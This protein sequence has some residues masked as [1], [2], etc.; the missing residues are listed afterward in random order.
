M[1]TVAIPMGSQ[2]DI[3]TLVTRARSELASTLADKLQFVV[4]DSGSNVDQAD[5]WT[6][7]QA[8]DEADAVTQ[9]VGLVAQGKADILL[10]GIVQTHTLL[11]ELLRPDY[12]LRLQKVLSHVAIIHLPQLNRPLLLSDAGMNIDPDEDRLAAI[13]ENA[14]GV[15]HQ[16]GLPKPKVALLSAAENFNPKMPSS[17]LAQAVAKQFETRSDAVIA[18]PISLDL[19]LSPASVAHKHYEGGIQG[20]ADV[21]IVPT[22]DV[23]NVLYKALMLFTDARSGGTIVGAKVPIVLTSRSDSVDSKLTALAFAIAQL[24]GGAS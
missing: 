5:T 9:A 4:F 22:I 19:A 11:K 20:D 17:V 1:I 23:G 15:A 2:P 8:R 6:F 7:H 12:Q 24:K 21:L 14:V 3:L 13:V 16:I 10:K 18:G